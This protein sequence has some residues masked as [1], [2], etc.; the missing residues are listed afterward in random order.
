MLRRRADVDPLPRCLDFDRNEDWHDALSHALRHVVPNAARGAIASAAPRYAE[1]AGTL[2]FRLADRSA[3]IDAALAWI[4]SSILSAYHGTRLTKVEEASVRADGL[5]P[6]HGASRRDQLVHALS[7]HPRWRELEPLLDDAIDRVG[8]GNVCG[9]R[10]GQVHLTLSRE[11]LVKG[12]NHYLRHGSEFDQR[13]VQLLV[14]ND[15]LQLFEQHGVPVVVT[16]LVPGAQALEAAHPHFTVRMMRDAGEVPNLVRSFLNAWA[17][18]LA[19]P[20]FRSSTLQV[21]VGLVFRAPVPRGWI[22]AITAVDL[23]QAGSA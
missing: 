8:P 18:R 13:V 6:L 19:F 14:G 1:D 17:Y 15:A 22:H 11:S 2:L 12:F 7:I 5:L 9:H 23:A 20:D 10:E 3:V 21:D 4:D 16:V